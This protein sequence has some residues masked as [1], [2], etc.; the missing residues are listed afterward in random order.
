MKADKIKPT[1]VLSA[2]CIMV[3][4]ILSS[5]NMITGPIIEAR[6]NAS[7]NEALLVVM[8]DGEGFE[9]LDVA[10]LGLPETVTAA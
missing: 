1:I 2:I 6:R 10:T 5:I 7:A 4:V 9:E 3:A 8:P